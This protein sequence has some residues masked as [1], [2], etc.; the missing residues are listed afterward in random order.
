MSFKITGKAVA[1]T[2][3]IAVVAGLYAAKATGVTKVFST[4]TQLVDTKGNTYVSLINRTERRPKIG[5]MILEPLSM[6]RIERKWGF[7]RLMWSGDIT[8]DGKKFISEP[9]KGGIHIRGLTDF[10]GFQV[11]VSE[12]NERL[13]QLLEAPFSDKAEDL[14]SCERMN[15]SGKKADVLF[16]APSITGLVDGKKTYKDE[17]FEGTVALQYDNSAP[18]NNSQSTFYEFDHFEKLRYVDV[19]V[20]DTIN[21]ELTF[22]YKFPPFIVNNTHGKMTSFYK[23]HRSLDSQEDRLNLF[24]K[25]A[26][27]LMKKFGDNPERY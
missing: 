5:G 23:C 19:R 21:T 26:A 17:S 13:H 8:I 12:Y 10:V 7:V 1:G 9:V 25:L 6:I 2:I 27:D 22:G 14:A 24:V 16:S 15:S 4:P 3:A 18:Y 11:P 20:R